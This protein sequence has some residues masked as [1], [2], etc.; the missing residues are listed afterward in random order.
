MGGQQHSIRVLVLLCRFLFRASGHRAFCPLTSGTHT[1]FVCIQ[2]QNVIF[3]FNGDK[4][5]TTIL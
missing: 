1:R 2:R 4:R 5:A 3:S